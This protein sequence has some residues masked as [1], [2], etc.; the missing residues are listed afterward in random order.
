MT[1]SGDGAGVK[2][3]PWRERRTV[4]C[5]GCGLKM[6]VE[7]RGGL[8]VK[9]WCSGG[10]KIR[11]TR[12]RRTLLIARVLEGDEA[13]RQRLLELMGPEIERARGAAALRAERIVQQGGQFDD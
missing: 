7:V 12:R 1:E 9:Q 13:A 6:R 5:R 3:G 8:L 11:A 2:E 10:C 4:W